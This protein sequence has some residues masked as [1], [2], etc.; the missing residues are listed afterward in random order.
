MGL[1]PPSHPP[2][3]FTGSSICR[4]RGSPGSRSL[5]ATNSSPLPPLNPPHS[6]TLSSP[7]RT[8]SCP[9]LPNAPQILLLSEPLPLPATRLAS[10]PPSGCSGCLPTVL[11]LPQTTGI[12]AGRACVC[13][14]FVPGPHPLFHEWLD[15]CGFPG[16]IGISLYHSLLSSLTPGD[17]GL[18]LNGRTGTGTQSRPQGSQGIGRGPL[19]PVGPRSL[20]AFH[21]C[22]VPKAPEMLLEGNG[23]GQ[24]CK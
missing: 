1:F 2:E 13:P 5:A 9:L 10:I 16:L 12:S 17:V 18:S 11:C 6:S 14:T 23:R 8:P 22:S 3:T 24:L 20:S 21:S 4:V 19:T 15:P 7:L